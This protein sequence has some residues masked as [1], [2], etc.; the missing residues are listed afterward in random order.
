M[1]GRNR[2]KISDMQSKQSAS[3][4]LKIIPLAEAKAEDE[5]SVLPLI[6]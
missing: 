2:T 1:K 5:P 4:F 3:E 6:Q